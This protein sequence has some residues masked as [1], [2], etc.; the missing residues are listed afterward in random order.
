MSTTTASTPSGRRPQLESKNKSYGW[1]W[2]RL[3]DRSA[4]QSTASSK[5]D[6]RSRSDSDPSPRITVE[7]ST[8]R[9]P[10]P[11]RVNEDQEANEA[12]SGTKE[13]TTSKFDALKQAPSNVSKSESPKGR[14][15]LTLP[16]NWY[17]TNLSSRPVLP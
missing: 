13:M 14:C 9:R 6:S 17:P 16:R 2:P 12:G 3:V 8:K 4:A 5:A 15:E 10:M 11:E 7:V 1:G